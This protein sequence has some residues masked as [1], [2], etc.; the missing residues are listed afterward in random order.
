MNNYQ[1]SFFHGLGDCVYFAHLIALYQKRGFQIKVNCASDKRALFPGAWVVAPKTP[2]PRVPWIHGSDLEVLDSSNHWLANKPM[3]NLSASPMPNIGP[4]SNELW[5]ELSAIR[6]DLS[7]QLPTADLNEVDQFFEKLERPIILLHTKGNTSQGSKSVPDALAVE[8]Y[9]SILDETGGTVLL[10]DWDSRVPVISHGRIKHLTS[11][12]KKLDLKELLAAIV[13]SDLL[14]GVDSG[15]LHL[16]RFTTTPCVG[17]WFN[18][19]HPAKYSLPRENQVNIILNR[20]APQ[21]NKHTRW[22]FNIIEEQGCQIRASIVGRT[23]R[24][25]LGKPAYLAE[26][27]IGKDVM[28]QHW[29]RDKTRGGISS[30][31]TFID[32]DQSFDFMLRYACRFAQPRIVETGCIRAE[33]DWRG[34]GFSTYLFGAYVASRGGRLDSVDTGVSNCAFAQKWTGIYGDAVQIHR[35]DSLQYLFNRQ[36]PIDLLYLD[37]WDIYNSGYAEHGLNEIQAAEKVL[38]SQSMVVYDDTSLQKKCWLGKGMLGV[39]WLMTKGWKPVFVG[40]QT[41]LLRQ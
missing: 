1:V 24:Q 41:L 25:M 23:C 18:G 6:I 27:Q 33:E 21:G 4:P 12:W 34:A 11:D 17:L 26:E 14:V 39:P 20:E 3:K 38:H 30:Q 10:L 37:S 28:L 40:H 7:A 36:E 32:R 19:H 13:R 16:C 2:A 15:P 31:N 8:I 22:F 35:E 5:R 29:V 9:R